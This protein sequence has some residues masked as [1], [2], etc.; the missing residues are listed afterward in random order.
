MSCY[1][2]IYTQSHENRSYCSRHRYAVTTYKKHTPNPSGV[3]PSPGP[4]HHNPS[5][6]RQPQRLH[7]GEIRRAQPR[8][9][10]PAF[11]RTEPVRPAS[12]IRAIGDVVQHLGMRVQ[13]RIDETNR[14]L[15]DPQPRLDD[16]VDDGREDG[17]GGRGAALEREVSANVD[18]DV[19]AV[20]G[21][22]WDAPAVAV[23]QA[24]AAAA[25][26]LA[27]GV[28]RVRRVVVGEE[29]GDGGFLVVRD[30]EDV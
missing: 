3:F 13:H 14:T 25:V 23:V 5:R 29:R 18:G 8:H 28:V 15:A 22:V 26:V 4:L 17:R 10:I 21:Y 30:G 7:L 16:P 2:A 12:R 9:R 20:C 24:A 11:D 6:Q 19:V 27:V 1:S